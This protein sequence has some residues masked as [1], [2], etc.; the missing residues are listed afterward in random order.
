[1]FIR[2]ILVSA[3]S[4]HRGPHLYYFPNAVEQRP[5]R[6]KHVTSG[7]AALAL[8]LAVGLVHLDSDTVTETT[9]GGC[10]LYFLVLSQPSPFQSIQPRLSNSRPPCVY[11][12]RTL[13]R[14][15][16]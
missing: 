10:F 7:A 16:R 14:N 1:M 4:R 6:L 2:P 11:H 12:S 8:S 5:Q 13:F 15:S 3:V 9:V